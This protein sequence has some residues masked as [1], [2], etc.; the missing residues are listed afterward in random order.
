MQ[1]GR[2]P[3]A[4]KIQ[5][6]VYELDREAAELR[7][8]GVIIR[9]QQQPLQVLAVLVDRP[10]EI[11]TREQLQERIWG[12]DTF[13]DFEQ[14]LNKAV[15]RLREALNDDAAQPRYIETVPRRG[16]RF[17]APVTGDTAGEP[18][19]GATS[20]TAV[21]DSDV[22]KLGT[23]RS[24]LL[25]TTALVMA[26]MLV[27]LGVAGLAL[28]RG[29]RKP[30]VREITHVTS[31]GF[32][33]T[34]SRDGKL[35]VYVSAMGSDPPHIWLKQTAGGAA[36]QVTRGPD[37]DFWPDFSPDGTHIAFL[38]TRGGGGLFIAPTL[39]GEP[40]LVISKRFDMTPLASPRFSPKGDKILFWEDDS[41]AVTV[42]LGGGAPV[43]LDLS[44]DFRVDEPPRWS[45][46]GDEIIFYG[47]RKRDLEK[48]RG[49]WIVPLNGGE[50]KPVDL[51]AAEEGD[52]PG[53]VHAW[54]RTKD[55]REWIVY[56]VSNRDAWK[57]LRVEISSRGQID[58]KPEQLISG[59]GA[60]IHSASLS[61]DGKLT[62]TITR[63]SQSIYEIPIN[64]RG[65]KLGPILQLPLSG[66]SDESSPSVSRDGRWMA[67][68]AGTGKPNTV[69]VRDFKTVSDRFL[70]DTDRSGLWGEASISPDG[71]KV[72]FERDC[73]KGEFS[74]GEPLPCSFMV[75]SA[76]GG[77]EQ[78]CE[79]CTPRGFS[80][81][82]SVVLI[83]KYNRIGEAHDWISTLDLATKTEKDFLNIPG[84]NLYHAYFSW[85]DN[86]VVFKG[87]LGL[88]NAQLLIAP[89]RKGVAGKQA[90]WI[91]V[92]DGRS[93]D[94]KPQFSPDG[95]TI[96]FTSTRDG[97]LCIW[98]QRLDPKT[99][100]P[101]D[102]PIPYEHFHNSIGRDASNPD[103][104]GQSD[105]T[106]APDKILINLPEMK[107]DIW[108]MQVE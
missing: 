36:I 15:N 16:Y 80:S 10:G 81:D 38:S 30:T 34:L 96:Y 4:S 100:R 83:Q 9:L 98:T 106:V 75:S 77:P 42:P 1:Y 41:K 2:D 25:T 84:K 57:L 17:V 58:K 33:A 105:L 32:G 31:A 93:S 21:L 67:Y 7:K 78:V 99:K 45:P 60:P 65:L 91:P 27:A 47:I 23:R 88:T 107:E 26:G 12:K 5:F 20:P 39:A 59:T 74:P 90:E 28:L 50:P 11:V 54:I 82:G 13:V 95:N 63:F 52:H 73:K 14:S 79:F 49:I 37:A 44:R 53:A 87:L 8:H 68:A 43:P 51:P 35:L 40:K 66:E 3:L 104:Q 85:D 55:G 92:T 76:G 86:W 56:S 48:P 24:S 94:D 72:I 101:L 64:A 61:E 62:Y 103:L 29:H 19:R 70:D 89:V 18:G 22:T 6:G 46:S 97:Y 69:L 108:L 102:A 71:S